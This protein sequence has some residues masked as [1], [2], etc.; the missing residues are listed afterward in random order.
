MLGRLLLTWLFFRRLL[1]LLFRSLFALLSLL[2]C[3]R[4]I[5]LGRLLLRIFPWLLRDLL[6][7]H[8]FVLYDRRYCHRR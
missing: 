6:C 3:R 8:L 7:R 2:L 1:P 4:A 5:L